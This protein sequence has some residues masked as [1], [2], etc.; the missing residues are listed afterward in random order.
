MA[1][2]KRLELWAK[3]ALALVAS[4]LFW[5]PG[6]RLR[7]GSSLPVPRKVLLVRPDNRVGEAL[8]TTPL[9]RTLKA[10]VHPVPEVHVLVHAKVARV[11]AGHPDADQVIAFDRRRLW[12]GPLAPG[13]RALR[14]AGYDLVVDC[15]NWEAPS[16]TSALVAR[17]AGPRAVV[18]GPSVWPVTRLHSLSVPARDD[19]RS[20]ALQRTHLLTPVTGG[21]LS[22]GLSFREPTISAPFRAFLETDATTPRAVINPGGRLGPRRIPPEA[23][24]AAA[25]ALLE[26]GRVPIVTWGPGEE[27]LARAVVAAAPGSRLAPAT[28]LDE[29]AALMRA[30]GLTICNNTGPM[31]LSVSVGAPTLAYFLRMDM[32]RWGHA[33]APHRM[34]DLTSLVDGAGGEGLEARAAEEARTFAAQLTRQA[35][36]T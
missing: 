29:L 35:R 2:H 26:I 25:R 7:P 10:H 27:E 28:N 32:E 30:A 13:I 36:P 34:V 5:R 16:V 33:Y 8:L 1:W 11:L 17:L 14:R 12:M 4:V 22:R 24:A 9:M 31:H 15:A 21:T 3:L 23:F 18:I 20:E 19:S 6:R